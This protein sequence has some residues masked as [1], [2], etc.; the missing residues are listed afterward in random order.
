MN[1]LEKRYIDGSYLAENPNWDREDAPW[2]AAIVLHILF[3]NQIKPASICEVGCG[4][5]DILI[6]LAKHLPDTIMMGFDI[7]PQAA[8]FWKEHQ[9]TNS[10]G[11]VDFC[12]GDFHTINKQKFDLLLMIDVF[13]HVRD[14]FSFLENSRQH[15]ANFVF[16]IPLDLS[17]SS[18]LRGYP[19]INARKKTGHLHYY[20]K[21]LALAT[22]V[23]TGYKVLD[24]R[25][26]GASLD[27]PNRSL[28]TRLTA[29]PRRIAYAANK[30]FGVRLLGGETLLVLA[31]PSS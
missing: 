22:L 30:D 19:L 20:T 8:E 23:D 25:Y 6:H 2:K 7:S 5:G 14:P 27:M 28:R 26:T 11:G 31:K 12:L 29:L 1:N 24:W 17:A 15:A 9:C 21:D 3:D 18:I 4:S 16:H 13:E 10:G